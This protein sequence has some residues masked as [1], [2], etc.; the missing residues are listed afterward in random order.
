MMA[1]LVDL[2]LWEANQQLTQLSLYENLLYSSG[3]HLITHHLMEEAGECQWIQASSLI[4][5][6]IW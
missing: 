4:P 1:S 6:G 2:E 5:G 3:N